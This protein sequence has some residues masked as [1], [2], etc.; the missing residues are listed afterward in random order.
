MET[1][2]NK[3][4]WFIL[5][6][7]AVGSVQA[8]P[9]YGYTGPGTTSHL[10]VQMAQPNRP[11]ERAANPT[12]TWGYRTA[13]WV[14]PWVGRVRDCSL[15]ALSGAATGVAIGRNPYV[16]MATG[17]AG[18]LSPQLSKFRPLQAY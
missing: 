7:M 5:A 4:L 12:E 17:C 1:L 18:G 6:L 13:Y 3:F 16:G 2:F 11:S 9:Y 8:Q 14:T 15:G 10:G